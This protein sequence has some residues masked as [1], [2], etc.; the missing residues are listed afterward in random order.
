MADGPVTVVIANGDESARELLTRIV[1]DAG[2]RAVAVTD[3]AAVAAAV[4]AEGAGAVLLDLGPANTDALAAVRG[5]G[6]AA[7]ASCR[8]VV[9]G[10]GDATGRLAWS[11]GA[12]GYLSRPFHVDDLRAT[13]AAALTRPEG[14]RAAARTTGALDPA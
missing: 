7:V 1:A 3:G 12:D 4:A 13:L 2:H 6:D 11:G 10:A 5:H 14:D 8:A 9:L